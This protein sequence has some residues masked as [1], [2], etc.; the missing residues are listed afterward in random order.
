MKIHTRKTSKEVQKRAARGRG[1]GGKARGAPTLTGS[2]YPCGHGHQPAAQQ[3]WS[4]RESG[5]VL[6][7]SFHILLLMGVAAL[8]SGEI[9]PSTRQFPNKGI[10]I[11]DETQGNEQGK[12]K[13]PE[14]AVQPAMWVSFPPEP[15]TTLVLVLEERPRPQLARATPIAPGHF[16]LLWS[17]IIQPTALPHSSPKNRGP[18]WLTRLPCIPKTLT[19]L[20]HSQPGNLDPQGPGKMSHWLKTRN[21]RV[22]LVS[23]TDGPNNVSSQFPQVDSPRAF[24]KTQG[25]TED[26]IKQSACFLVL[27]WELL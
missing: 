19:C 2:K 4:S 1:V 11:K 25:L 7:V 15:H 18:L 14:D 6:S 17:L 16:L 27:F 23:K 5:A 10:F 24:Q 26:S 8:R 21:P 12:D 13:W 9:F 20:A 3:R 22:V